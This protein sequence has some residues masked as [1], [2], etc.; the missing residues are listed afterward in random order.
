MVRAPLGRVWFNNYRS[1]ANALTES[2]I[3]FRSGSITSAS[4]AGLIMPFGGTSDGITYQGADG[5]L[6]N[7]ASASYDDH[8]SNVKIASGVSINAT[9]FVGEAGAVIDLTGGGSLDAARA[10]SPAVAARSMC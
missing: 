1:I 4:A 3:T 9:S 5:T 8:T 10:S 6:R 7:L 2:H